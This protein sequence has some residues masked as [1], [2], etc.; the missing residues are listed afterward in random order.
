MA[1]GLDIRTIPILGPYT[2]LITG[3]GFPSCAVVAG[4]SIIASAAA[5]SRY[6]SDV[7]LYVSITALLSLFIYAITK[8]DD[9]ELHR[10]PEFNATSA[11]E[12]IVA[13]GIASVV[14][15]LVFSLFSI[16]RLSIKPTDLTLPLLG[17]VLSP[18]IEGLFCAAFAPILAVVLRYREGAYIK[19]DAD[20]KIDTTA[21]AVEFRNL[22]AALKTALKDTTDL[23]AALQAVATDLRDAG[24]NAVGSLRG[25]GSAVRMEA[26]A[27]AGAFKTA[28][29]SATAASEKL[30]AMNKRI[31]ETGNAI[32]S[33]KARINEGTTLLN[34]LRDLIAS[35][36]R[37]IDRAKILS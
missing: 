23:S 37:F 33:F 17:R 4:L 12:V 1:R 7:Y 5:E 11:A 34:G 8:L 36:Q 14:F 25:L 15:G 9:F 18:F 6:H 32:E 16:L 22:T 24:K 21:L 35:V 10:G 28:S 2:R 30:G 29:D 19:A 27:A 20:E 3:F 31:E 26:D 13:L